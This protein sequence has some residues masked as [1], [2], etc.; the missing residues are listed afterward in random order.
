MNDPNRKARRPW[1][2]FFLKPKLQI[3]LTYLFVLASLLASFFTVAGVYLIT[4]IGSDGLEGF[5]TAWF[6]LQA[7]LPGF[8][9]AIL[10]SLTVGL[11]VGII[12]SRKVA[13]PI[14][15]VE[16]WIKN[17]YKGDFTARLGMRNEDYWEDMSE[18]CD[19]FI[20]SMKKSL[21]RLDAMAQN[22]SSPLADEVRSFL[23]Q[24]KY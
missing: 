8:Y 6:Y 9:I 2:N 21:N 19:Q 13:L 18:S 11:I 17:L 24:Y 23:K 1:A 15:K 3:K 5:R 4:R 14:Y 7:L 22:D 20:D 12:A 10:I 16:Q